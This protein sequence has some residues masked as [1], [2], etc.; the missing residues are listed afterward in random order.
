[1]EA[2]RSKKHD[3]LAPREVSG[4]ERSLLANMRHLIGVQELLAIMMV[5]AA[6]SSAV[7][8]WKAT[9]IY[10]RGERPYIGVD[11]IQLTSDRAGRPYVAINYRNV[12]PV[13]SEQTVLEASS[14]VDGNLASYDPA[15]PGPSK[16]RLKLGVLSPH[17]PHLFAAYF[18]PD[19]LSAIRDGK[20]QLQVSISISYQ[21]ASREEYCYQMTF[22]YYAPTETFDPAG[23][24]GRCEPTS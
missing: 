1:M 20:S 13:P 19:A 16:I 14:T 3:E 4:A 22:R 11:S 7:A 9:Q 21:G 18:Q 6:I 23:G 12:G 8:T 15:D 24:S 5:V 17:S 2:T 10:A